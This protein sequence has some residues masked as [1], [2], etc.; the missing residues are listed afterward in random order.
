MKRTIGVV[1]ILFSALVPAAHPTV[2]LSLCP[3][4]AAVPADSQ[5]L[6]WRRAGPDAL[7]E[8]LARYDALPD[9]EEKTT[10]AD[11]I[12]RVAAQKYAHVS[13]LY[14]FTDLDEARAAA[15]A[16]GKPILSL[17]L[18]GRLDEDLSCA[19]SRFFR[20]A[21]YANADLSRFLR[22]HFVLHWSS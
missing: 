12:D 7:A 15:R 19:N 18:L 22:E 9:G 5:V 13:R 11:V 17:R 16:A 4:G 1:M 3:P 6:A 8:L 10:L 2:S 20:V 14:W 21:L